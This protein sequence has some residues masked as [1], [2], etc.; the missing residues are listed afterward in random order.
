[1][2]R[3]FRGGWSAVLLLCGTG[4]FAAPIDITSLRG[5]RPIG[6]RTE[7][8]ED[9]S[10]QLEVL[11]VLKSQ[12]FQR[13]S[14]A[15][16][17][18][19]QT[20]FAYWF[21]FRLQNNSEAV[22]ERLLEVD[23]SNID[24]VDFYLY[25]GDRR[26]RHERTGMSMPFDTRHFIHR[27]FVFPVSVPPATEYTVLLRLKTSGGLYVPLYLWTRSEFLQTYANVQHGLGIYYGVMLVMILY[28]LFVFVTVKDKSY[29]YY[30]LYIGAFLG[31][32]LTLT[33]HG[34]QYIWPDLPWLQ[35]NAY[36]MFTGICLSS[37]IT[38]SRRFL[39][40]EQIVG[41]RI[42]RAVKIY[43]YML[44]A[45]IGSVFIV[46]PEVSVKIALLF[47]VP[48]P[49]IVMGLAIAALIK[50]FRPARY[51]LLAFTVLIVSG[52]VVALQ[53]L[54]ILPSSF[55]TD[56]GLYVGSAMEV[57]LLSIALADRINVM[58]QEKEEAQARAIEMQKVL[59]ESYARF[60]P[61]DFLS[62]LGK[63][64]ILDVRPGDQVQ[65]EMAVLFSD[66]RSFTTLSEQMTPEE[67]FNFINAYL[68][69]MNPI[70]QKHAGYIDKYI[71]DAIM[72]L[73]ERSIID[74]IRAGV[75]MQRYL[76]QYN[77]TRAHQGFMPVRI[78]I[79]IHSGTLM[80]G[81][82]GDEERLEGTVISDTVNL[83]ARIEN[84]TKVYGVRI[85]V[86]ETAALSINENGSSDLHYR[87]LDRVRVKGKAKPISVYEVFSGDEDEAIAKKME[88]RNTFVR[89]ASAFHSRR[90]AEARELFEEVA[91]QFPEDTVTQLYLNRLM[92]LSGRE[93]S[94]ADMRWQPAEGSDGRS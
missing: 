32:Q 8:L 50:G 18:P 87:F 64:S 16:P 44:L 69:R 43:G 93:G 40:A 17:N 47:T 89:A 80:L 46:P 52:L 10:G 67:N 56:Y 41:P 77:E 15:V 25:S 33:G 29:L 61:R 4:L 94:H 84:L 39:N 65:K 36:V 54:S 34:F 14:E 55:L 20:N 42:E 60:V 48:V 71:G 92:T 28:N 24:E 90:L 49:V 79:G 1:M 59:T 2:R 12:D 3:R 57:I 73:F 83:A 51:F 27:N 6:E 91:E 22:V 45:L 30:V 21:R 7:I 13:P 53:F 37:L 85:A 38:F 31:I 58:K 88:T 23:Y 78:G 11:Q 63:E 81:T 19:G 74:A 26:I 35:R 72:A 68:G 76:L 86:S 75:E 62:M 66:I 5:D 9:R 82:I 70:I